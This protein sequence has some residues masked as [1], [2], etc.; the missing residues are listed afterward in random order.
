MLKQPKSLFD[1]INHLIKNAGSAFLRLHFVPDDVEQRSGVEKSEDQPEL[2]LVHEARVVRHDVL[3][4]AT[5]HGLQN[6]LDKIVIDLYKFL[7]FI[8]SL[9]F[10]L[11]IF[12]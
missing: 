11:F 7:A 1:L 9:K 4:I 5:W 12:F 6:G 10:K 8:S 2:L 3:V